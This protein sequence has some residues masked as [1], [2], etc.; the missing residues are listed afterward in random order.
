MR[1]LLLP[2]H[3]QRA[4]HRGSGRLAAFRGVLPP[5]D[6][7]RSEDWVASTTPRRG[8]SLEGLTIL[9]DGRLLRAAVEADLLRWLGVDHAQ[10][11]GADVG[12][13]VKLVDTGERA[14]LHAHP[15]AVAWVIVEAAP[16]A[17][18]HLGF[19]RRVGTAELTGRAGAGALLDDVVAVPVRAGDALLCPAGVP[20]ALGAGILAI[21]VREAADVT[22][23]LERPSPAGSLDLV[24]RGGW[25]LA[26]ID[27]E[28]RGRPR[29]LRDGVTSLLPPAADRLFSAELVRAHP[30]VVLD[31]A[32]SVV[33]VLEGTGLLVWTDGLEPLDVEAGD[34]VVVPHA[35]GP[36]RV[37]GPLTAVRCRPA[38]SRRP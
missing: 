30:R 34:A 32:F 35:A 20:H 10:T 22:V 4:T 14:P 11:R 25:D 33:V 23:A 15:V 7:Y 6:P 12:M 17:V 13:L 37:E 3:L 38:P 31:A 21:E 29:P 27:A 16:D 9:P 2:A 24:D 1:P 26:R 19:G 5:G 8:R 36:C 18:V 28:L